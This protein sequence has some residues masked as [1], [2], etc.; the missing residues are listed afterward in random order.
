MIADIIK[1][2]AEERG[3]PLIDIHTLATDHPDWF[4]KD[5]VHPSNAGA[6][7]IAEAVYSTITENR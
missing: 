2:I 5:G 7:A 3:Y 6:A 4:R 1:Q